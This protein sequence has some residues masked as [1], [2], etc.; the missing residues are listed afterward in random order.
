MRYEVKHCDGHGHDGLA[1]IA[2][3]ISVVVALIRGVGGWAM[4][5]KLAQAQAA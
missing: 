2:G 4:S 3:I 5:G 1:R